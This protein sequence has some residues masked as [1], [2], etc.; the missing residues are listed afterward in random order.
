MRGGDAGDG[1]VGALH[2]G[3]GANLAVVHEAAAGGHAEH[4]DEDGGREKVSGQ[5]D[6]WALCEAADEHEH[7]EGVD[8]G[9]V[10]PAVLVVADEVKGERGEGG[11]HGGEE[12]A[13]V[14]AS[15]PGGPFALL[16]DEPGGDAEERG[17]G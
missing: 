10:R 4:H 11:G 7:E 9:E 6:S 5:D 2:E 15:R 1:L 13:Q 3:E 16:E 8:A 12:E 14:G 17:G